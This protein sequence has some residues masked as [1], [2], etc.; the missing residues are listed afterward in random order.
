MDASV[1]VRTDGPA[2]LS[3]KAAA[4]GHRF[5]ADEPAALGGGDTGPTPGELLLG[6]LGACTA[7]TL[8]MYA[9]R[10]GWDLRSVEVDLAFS[11]GEGGEKDRI[12]RVIRLEGELDTDQRER[13]L[14]I[15]GK[16][17]VHRILD[18]GAA[19]ETVAGSAPR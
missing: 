9:A 15:A 18:A 8:R 1:I 5:P 6:A 19:L 12:R 11:K 17:P 7:I 14:E 16:C 10:K 13:L 2:G 3:V 4:R